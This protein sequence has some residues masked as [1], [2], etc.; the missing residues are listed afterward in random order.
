MPSSK[1]CRVSAYSIPHDDGTVTYG[2]VSIFYGR[3]NTVEQDRPFVADKVIAEAE[4]AAP[5]MQRLA[6]PAWTGEA[7]HKPVTVW[8][9]PTKPRFLPPSGGNRQ[10]K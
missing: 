3:S 2:A 7:G 4:A 6:R 10:T 1:H 9:E 8:P 5:E